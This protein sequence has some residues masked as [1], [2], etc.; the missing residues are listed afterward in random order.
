[1]EPLI[2][3]GVQPLVSCIMPTYNRRRFVPHALRYFQRQEYQNKELII[4]DD[5]ADNIKDL[6][7]VD[8]SIKYIRLE[9][10][11]SL[12]EKLNIACSSASGTIIANWDDDDWYA[13]RRLKYQ[14]DQLNKNNTKVCGIN[15]LLYFDINHRQAY[16]YK[17]PNNQPKW[18]LGSSLCYF[19]THWEANPFERINVGM[20]GLFVWR[21]PSSLVTV[22]PDPTMSVHMIHDS[23]ISPKK[24][25]GDWWH[26]YPVEEIEQIMRT[27]LDHYYDPELQ[28]DKDDS[29]RVRH[30][31][32]PEKNV[33]PIKNIYACLVH[34]QVDCVIDMVRN[35]H[36]NDPLSTI[37]L[38]SGSTDF[39]LTSCFFPFE[40]FGAIICPYTRKVEHGYL[41]QFALDCMEF[42]LENFSFDILT[43]VDSD[44][45]SLKPGYSSF[46]G[47]FFSDKSDIGLLSNK[48]ERLTAEDTDV[49]TCIQPFHEFDLW[50]PFLKT[51]TKGEE[52]FVHWSFWP[53]TV[54]TSDAARDLVKIFK[55]NKQLQYVMERT[56]IWATEEIIL[57]TLVRLLGYQVDLNPCCH[58]F[59]NYKKTY[60]VNDLNCAIRTPQ[61]YW[62]H[63]VP[64]KYDDE[65]RKYTR[66]QLK[67]YVTKPIPKESQL[68]DRSLFLPLQTLQNIQEIEGWLSDSEADLLIACVLKAC[69]SVPEGQIV[70]V[71]CYRGKATILMG[72][73]AKSISEKIK[74]YAIDKH[75][76]LLGSVDQGL[77][78]F[79]PSFDDLK[80]NIS[81]Y[82]LLETIIPLVGLS[83]EVRWDKEISFLLIDGLHDYLSISDDFYRFAPFIKENGFVAFHDYADYFPDVQAFVNDLIIRKNYLMVHLNDSLAVL[84]KQVEI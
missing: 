11:I 28:V 67:S 68:T 7:P 53:S 76:G 2:E 22:L 44:Q 9:N 60:S 58:D 37:I 63:P 14:V 84:R 5:G 19:R 70:E 49:W 69:T 55:T 25:G 20:D 43:I 65:I 29:T 77:Y 12:G 81:K 27:D 24:T 39:R 71:G 83:S 40:D 56:K 30:I 45:L 1:M 13:P 61:A 66:T 48:P 50:K 79:K 42:A 23:N 3:H 26:Q 17:Y 59:V 36:F 52:K 57:P 8:G 46:M 35:L 72:L 64:R 73:L 4:V 16:Q 75:D 41:H 80:V 47:E 15:N 51:F 82:S 6:I 32:A 10:K 33:T 21:T 78:S 62:V 34:E 38:F 54:F 18:L 31:I 74:V